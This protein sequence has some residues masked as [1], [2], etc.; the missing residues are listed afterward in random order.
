VRLDAD[1]HPRPSPAIETIAYFCVAELLANAA[2]H[3][4]AN[5]VTVELPPQA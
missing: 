1:V 2:K 5:R 3:S 4:H